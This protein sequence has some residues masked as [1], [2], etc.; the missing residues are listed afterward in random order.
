MTPHGG[1]VLGGGQVRA[2]LG[3]DPLDEQTVAAAPAR[4]GARDDDDAVVLADEHPAG[5]A[6]VDAPGH[7]R[8]DDPHALALVVGVGVG[9]RVGLGADEPVEVLG[10]PGPVDVPVLDRPLVEE[11]GLRPV[12]RGVDGL[13]GGEDVKGLAHDRPDQVHGAVEEVRDGVAVAHGK[14]ALHHDVPGVEFGVHE[15][16]CDSHLFLTVDQGPDERRE[17]G[18]GGQQ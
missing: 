14:S 8:L 17:T 1:E 7:R 2:V 16:R 18:V 12:L 9:I 3:A 15:V 10:G 13:A 6:A 5:G 11:A 4:L